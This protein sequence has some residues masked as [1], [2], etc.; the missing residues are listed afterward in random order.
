[1]AYVLGLDLGTSSLKG[2]LVNDKGE[3]IFSSS[4]NYELIQE[5]SGW[6]EQ[7]PVDWTIACD[8]LITEISENIV[9]FLSELEGISFSGQMHS[10]V[11]L[12]NK[13]QVLR[14]SIL[15]NDVRTTEEC[16]YIKDIFRKDILSITGNIP[17]EGFTLPKILWVKK[18]EPT[19]W[20]RVGKIL[21]P[22][23][24]LRYYLTGKYNMDFS[25]AAGTLLLDIQEKE[26]SDEV[27]RKFDIPKKLLPDLK[28]SSD[29]VGD[30]K[31]DIQKKYNIKNKVRVFA[32]GAD[33]ACGALGSGITEES[34]SMVS[35]GTSGVFLSF[36]NSVREYNGKLHMFNHAIPDSFYSM[37][38][39]LSAGHSLNW[40]KQI[41]GEDISFEDLLK[42]IDT[43]T[44]GSNGIFFT[45]YLN[46]ERSP[47]FNSQI[48]GSFIG[49]NSL[50]RRKHMVRSVIEGITFSLKNSQSIM[51]ELKGKKLNKIVSVGGGSKNKD[52]LQIQADIFDADI[53]TL[54]NDE[55]PSLGAC[56][57]AA[58]GLKWFNNF[59]EC[60][61]VFV[62]YSE[63]IYP[64]KENVD[65]Y[66]KL[67]EIYN[68]IYFYTKDLSKEILD[69]V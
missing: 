24:Y 26:W 4:V 54:S 25:D 55:G 39:T 1:M 28:E 63:P 57:L 13:G 20:E 56:M 37:G 33:N 29:Y 53:Y 49:L 15:W 23:D 16:E 22:K 11:L 58:V 12:D 17:L 8:K 36:E 41:I 7:N 62:S 59:N 27:L 40:F 32:G 14:N 18:N 19:I 3:K 2:L 48:T 10:L 34:V 5:K 9:D 46:G 47:H 50:H 35:I 64:N 69:I 21:L 43:V 68:K 31:E 52:W 6:N 45:P 66:N 30:L 61:D 44:P 38:V 60:K 51:A 67:Y 65:K 42:G